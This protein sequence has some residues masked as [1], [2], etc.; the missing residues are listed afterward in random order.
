LREL[1]SKTVFGTSRV[2]A[3]PSLEIEDPFHRCSV[4]KQNTTAT[5]IIKIPY[6]S[7]PFSGQSHMSNG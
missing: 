7:K 1:P 5:S 2:S 6:F 4:E 3:N